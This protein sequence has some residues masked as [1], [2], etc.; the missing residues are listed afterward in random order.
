MFRD[1]QL[2]NWLLKILVDGLIVLTSVNIPK[3]LPSTNKTHYLLHSNTQ[4]TKIIEI[5]F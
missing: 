2:K 5:K 3:V 4:Y 1:C